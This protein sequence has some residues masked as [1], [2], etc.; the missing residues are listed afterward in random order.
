M[1]YFPARLDFPSPPLSA[2]GSPRMAS[3]S[4]YFTALLPI[5]RLSFLSH[6][7][8]P[9]FWITVFLNILQYIFFVILHSKQKTLPRSFIEVV[10]SLKP[11]HCSCVLAGC[12]IFMFPNSL[13]VHAFITRAGVRKTDHHFTLLNQVLVAARL[14]SLSVVV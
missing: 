12:M 7:Q 1:S 8:V 9:F 6:M 3:I 10:Q 14:C 2:P 13:I 11:T 4:S 5:R